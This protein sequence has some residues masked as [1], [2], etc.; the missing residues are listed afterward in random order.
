[1]DSEGENV[2]SVNYVDEVLGRREVCRAFGTAP[3]APVAGT[4]AAPI[5]RGGLRSQGV[6]ARPWV[7]GRRNGLARGI[8]NRSAADG[9]FSGEQIL[10][11]AQ[12]CLGP[13]LVFGSNSADL[14][15]REGKGANML[16]EKETSTSEQFSQ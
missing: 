8:R 2:D 4:S 6:G 10:S 5:P 13:Q 7:L 14:F 1:M 9:R 11:E 15:R 16:Y 3:R 12:W